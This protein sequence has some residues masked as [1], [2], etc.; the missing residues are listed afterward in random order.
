MATGPEIQTDRPESGP[1]AES[2]YWQRLAAQ[3]HDCVTPANVLD[4]AGAVAVWYGAPQ[5]ATGRGIELCA[6]GYAKDAV[7]GSL[8]R[9]TKTDCQLGA[10]VDAVGDKV[11]I[12][13]GL[14]HLTKNRQV[15][16]THLALVGAYN[17]INASITFADRALNQE[18]QIEVSQ[19][20]KLAMATSLSGV[21]LSVIGNKLSHENR[22]LG[23]AV[24][25]AGF[26]T[27]LAG[28]AKFGLP[29]TIGYWHDF[30]AGAKKPWL[31]K[32]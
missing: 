5:L 26:I 20:G 24:Q 13:C 19:I 27:S 21:G 16:R 29:A 4:V 25:A 7:D 30:Q 28:I 15:P 1:T 3:T 22:Q 18:P 32:V 12:A 23:R 14:Y 11:N 31:K 8:A 17:V 10:M 2:S 9:F 6:F